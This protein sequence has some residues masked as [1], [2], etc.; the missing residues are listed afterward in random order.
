MT[1]LITTPRIYNNTRDRLWGQ[2]FSVATSFRQRW[3]N[4]NG[5]AYYRWYFHDPSLYSAGLKADLYVRIEGKR[6]TFRYKTY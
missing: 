3:G 2:E 5:G 4:L 1:F 6:P